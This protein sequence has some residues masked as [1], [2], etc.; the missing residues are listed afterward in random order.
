[1]LSNNSSVVLRS[2][3]PLFNVSISFLGIQITTNKPIN[4]IEN[5]IGKMINKKRRK[6]Y[7]SHEW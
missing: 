2:N 7:F 3:D 5:D 4:E 6:V 1:M